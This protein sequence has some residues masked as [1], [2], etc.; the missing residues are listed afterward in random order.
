V[1]TDP[2]DPADLKPLQP[3]VMLDVRL[4]ASA[5]DQRLQASGQGGIGERI[6]E[7]AW[8]RFDDGFSPLVFQ[9]ARALRQQVLRRFNPQF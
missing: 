3:V 2:R 1:S 6:G 5:A 4:D 7:R 9:W 8:V